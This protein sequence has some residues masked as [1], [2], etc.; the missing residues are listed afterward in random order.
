MVLLG[1][2]LRWKLESVRLEILLTL[3]QDRC[4]ICAERMIGFEIIFDAL[5]GTPR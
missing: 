4:T 2:R 5:D 3:T 1:A